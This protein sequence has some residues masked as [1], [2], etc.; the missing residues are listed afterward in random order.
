MKRKVVEVDEAS[1]SSR[2]RD[3][4]ATPPLQ[5]KMDKTQIEV[6]SIAPTALDG[7]SIAP[8][9]PPNQ[10]WLTQPSAGKWLSHSPLH[11]NTTVDG[12][13]LLRE[14]A[15]RWMA[16]LALD[17]RLQKDVKAAAAAALPLQPVQQAVLP[18]DTTLCE[19]PPPSQLP[20]QKT[21]SKKAEAL[22]LEGDC[23][24][25]ALSNDALRA[26]NAALREELERLLVLASPPSSAR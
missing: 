22:K 12:S 2:Q 5:D 26:E 19:L 16:P 14:P 18:K 13:W 1:Q 11:A 9:A 23:K 4:S 15:G 3:S 10:P 25:A 6:F 17:V 7:F 24:E 21:S 8:N 20:L